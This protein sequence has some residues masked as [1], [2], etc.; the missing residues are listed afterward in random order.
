VLTQKFGGLRA[1]L[2]FDNWPALL[3]V[4]LFDRKAGF[5][6]Y[7][8]KGLDI[9]IDHRGGDENGIRQCIASTCTATIC[10]P[11]SCGK[12]CG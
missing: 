3:L 6:A 5:V 7:R 4:R 1:I 11:L 10:R 8:K 12:R 2:A 9:L